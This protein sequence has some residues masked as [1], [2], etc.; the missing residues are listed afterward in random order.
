MD[1]KITPLRL[2]PRQAEALSDIPE[3][4]LPS[5][6]EAGAAAA[7]QQPRKVNATESDILDS[8]TLDAH[9]LS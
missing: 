2:Q 5:E 9:G 1:P 6:D 7:K 3:P 8:A 4:D